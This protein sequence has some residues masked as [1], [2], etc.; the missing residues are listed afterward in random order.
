MRLRTSKK[1]SFTCW[2]LIHES[3]SYS[4]PPHPAFARLERDSSF[5]LNWHHFE[6][7]VLNGKWDAAERY[8]S[9]FT[10][11]NENRFS[12]EMF[13]ALFKQKYLEALDR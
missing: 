2:M 12:M 9:G 1:M 6:E 10:R 4:S 13:F 11:L 7:L 3:Y 8:L 5:Y